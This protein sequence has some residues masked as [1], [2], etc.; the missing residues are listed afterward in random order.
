MEIYSQ[1]TH[2]L[3]KGNYQCSADLNQKSCYVDNFNARK[4]LNPNQSNSRS[5]IVLYFPF[6]SKYVDNFNARKLLN[7]NQSNTRSV[8]I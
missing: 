5:A 7:P 8:I 6:K 4:L 3:F 2:F 1:N